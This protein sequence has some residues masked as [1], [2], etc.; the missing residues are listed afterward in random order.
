MYELFFN[1]YTRY[2]AKVCMVND[3]QNKDT[4]YKMTECC[5]IVSIMCVTKFTG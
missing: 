2:T 4:R 1:T 5:L 3:A